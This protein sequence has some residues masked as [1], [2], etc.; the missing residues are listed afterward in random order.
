M[1]RPNTKKKAD[2]RKYCNKQFTYMGEIFLYGELLATERLSCMNFSVAGCNDYVT[3]PLR[4]LEFIARI[5]AQ[6]KLRNMWRLQLKAT[7]STLLLQ[8]VLPASIIER[9]GSGQRMIADAHENVTVLFSDI[10]GKV[11]VTVKVKVK[12]CRKSSAASVVVFSP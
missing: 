10:V 4:K 1:V 3:K 7:K 12:Q 2:G 8:E 6:L 5:D 9:L 11:K